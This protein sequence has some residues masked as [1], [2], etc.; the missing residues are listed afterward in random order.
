MNKRE[1]FNACHNHDWTFEYS[2]DHRY[3]VAG[4]K[5]QAILRAAINEHPEYQEIYDAWQKHAFGE[6]GRSKPV[7]RHFGLEE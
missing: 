7:P 2:D 1:F 3:W 4:N 6:A 5:Q